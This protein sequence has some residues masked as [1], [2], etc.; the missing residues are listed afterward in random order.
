[1]SKSSKIAIANMVLLTIIM[2]LAWFGI[3][4]FEMI[5]PYQWHKFLHLAGVVVFLGNVILG[6]LWFYLSLRD[7]NIETVKFTFNLLVAFDI[8]I[9][10]PSIFLVVINGLYLGSAIGGIENVD[11]LKHSVYSLII[12]WIFII[13]ILILQDKMVIHIKKG[14]ITS[15]AFKQLKTKWMTIGL[16]SFVPLVYIC[17]M[18]VFKNISI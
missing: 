17:Y 13:P 8:Y 4:S 1:M 11:W 18:M 9:T 2:L 16:I 7:N 12:L 3:F 6:P 5:L 10:A 14:D 15:Q